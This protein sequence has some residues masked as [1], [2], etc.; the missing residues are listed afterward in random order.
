[1][2]SFLHDLFR[3]LQLPSRTR[4]HT[5]EHWENARLLAHSRLWLPT[6]WNERGASPQHPAAMPPGDS[7]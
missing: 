3:A 5:S 4:D 1:M 7:A 2:A 6:R